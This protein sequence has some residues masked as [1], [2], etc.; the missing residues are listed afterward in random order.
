MQDVQQITS[1]STEITP[2]SICVWVAQQFG[3]KGTEVGLLKLS[4]T[5]LHFLHPAALKTA[6][7]IPS[8]ITQN[9]PIVI[10]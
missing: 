9:R 8:A 1:W 5:L 2:A 6:G 7:A 10:T 4:G 3:V